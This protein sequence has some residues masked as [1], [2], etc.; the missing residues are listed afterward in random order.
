M[1][2]PKWTINS[3]WLYM[4][5]IVAAISALLSII[6]TAVQYD[7]VWALAAIAEIV[8][9]V[10][11]SSVIPPAAKV[12]ITSITIPVCVTVMGALWGFWYL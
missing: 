12:M 4:S 7:L 9:G 5:G 10:V 3:P 2:L 6:T 8:L 11:I 1:E